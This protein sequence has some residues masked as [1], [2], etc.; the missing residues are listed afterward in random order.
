MVTFLPV[1]A[2][3]FVFDHGF[4]QRSDGVMDLEACLGEV[5]PVDA[6]VGA[7]GALHLNDSK[8]P[9]G[10]RVDRHEH[11]GRGELGL[12]AFRYVSRDDVLGKLPGYLETEKGTDEETGEDW[13][14]INLKVLRKLK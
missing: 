10:S 13:D 9:L 2:R 7:V 11:I 8:K 1:Q 12:K 6:P 14:V 3:Q 4:R 5:D